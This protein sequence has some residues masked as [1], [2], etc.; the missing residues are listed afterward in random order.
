MLATANSSGSNSGDCAECPRMIHVS[1]GDFL[2][3]DAAAYGSSEELPVHAVHV[4]PFQV[5]Q[6]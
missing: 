5:G 3:G 4:K 1:G 6:Y 2:M